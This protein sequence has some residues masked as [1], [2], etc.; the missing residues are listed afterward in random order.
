[1]HKKLQLEQKTCPV[2]MKSFNWRKKWKKDWDNVIYCSERCK[3][4]KNSMF[5]QST[6]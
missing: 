4:S 5:R 3:K 6:D 2:C 1:M